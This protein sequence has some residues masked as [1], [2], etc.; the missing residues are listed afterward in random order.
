MLSPGRRTCEMDRPELQP[1]L[2][3]CKGSI[4][5]FTLVF[6]HVLIMMKFYHVQSQCQWTKLER[7]L[8]FVK[9][10]SGF[11][12]WECWQY[13]H[14][15]SYCAP[16]LKR[17]IAYICSWESVSTSWWIFM[18]PHHNINMAQRR[19]EIMQMGATRFGL[20]FRTF[21]C[22]TLLFVIPTIFST[23]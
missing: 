5:K 9:F 3:L 17:H 1:D 21:Y 2:Y 8:S 12:N 15:S 20:D 19:T 4:N 14:K 6:I 7:K 10:K 22:L 16:S 11:I 18:R 13:N 23:S